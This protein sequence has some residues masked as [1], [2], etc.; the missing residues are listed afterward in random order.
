MRKIEGDKNGWQLAFKNYSAK[1]F[2]V[3][4]NAHKTFVTMLRFCHLQV[5]SLLTIRNTAS[6]GQLVGKTTQ[7]GLDCCD[8]AFTTYTYNTSQQLVSGKVT[9]AC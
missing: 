6:K 8:T 5:I 4:H 2:V 3:R 1:N 7:S 9:I